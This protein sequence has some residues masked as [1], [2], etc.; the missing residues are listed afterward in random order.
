MLEA[1]RIWKPNS[2]KQELFL[3]APDEVF[4]ILFGGSAGPGKSEVLM[5]LPLVR[6]FH[7]HPRFK[8][9]FFR[10]TFP[11]L[12]REI[13]PRS[14]EYYAS[15]GGRYNDQ[16]KVWEFPS[17]ARLFFGHLEHEDDVRKYDTS[18][19]NY[20]AFDELTSFTYFQYTYLSATRCRTSTNLP[21]IVR[22]ATNPG[23]VGH[24]WVKDKYNI[25]KIPSGVVQRDKVTGTLKMF[26][27]AFLTD[28]PNIDPGYA[29][30][31]ELL[32]EAEKRAKKY[33]DWDLFEGQVFSEFR[34]LPLSSEPARALHVIKPFDIPE[35]WPKLLVMDWGF[36]AYNYCLWAAIS[37]NGRVFIYREFACKKTYIEEWAP[38]TAQLSQ[39]EN[40]VDVI[41]DPSS[42]QQRGQPKTIF[43]QVSEALGDTL[44]AMLRTADNDR[45][46]GKLLVH[47][48]LRWTR[49]PD[50][51]I[52]ETGFDKEYA[53][54]LLRFHGMDAY[55]D[56]IKGF[57]EEKIEDE[58]ILPKL[59]IFDTCKLLIETIPQ[60]Q[61]VKTREGHISEDV[62]E[63]NGDD[64]YDDLRYLLKAVEFYVSNSS[65]KAEFLK[66]QQNIIEDYEKTK[67]YHSFYMKMR[68]LESKN[69][70]G[71]N[72][73]IGRF[74]RK[75]LNRKCPTLVQG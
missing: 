37:P 59:Q 49:R 57:E 39:D 21:A 73:Q 65:E 51:K 17:N 75:Q 4:E 54:N 12:E 19:F 20:E 10:R 18:E 60:C 7:Q 26:I 56:Y 29:A 2:K 30:R 48:Y 8:G 36:A 45:I 14:R 15:A 62:A 66:K 70:S 28:N 32:P 69:K 27:Q 42:K 11:E 50:T 41:I 53:N 43:Q 40:I 5:M 9:I 22:S 72:Q 52:T 44:G 34:I 3:S 74:G 47:E 25:G 58:S 46:G 24:R 6:G 67:N 68:H 55:Q 63:F 16:K 23:N 13:I 71:F 64:P 38:Q 31:L 35:W 61:Y 33:G 1:D